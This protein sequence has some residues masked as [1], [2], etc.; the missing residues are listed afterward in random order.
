MLFSGFERN[1]IYQFFFMIVDVF[2][3]SEILTY[4]SPAILSE[5]VSHSVRFETHGL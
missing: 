1:Y 5:S 2:Q 3:S 4:A